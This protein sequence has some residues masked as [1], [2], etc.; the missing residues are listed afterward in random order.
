M[1]LKNFIVFEGIDGAGTSTQIKIFADSEYKDKMDFSAEPTSNETG[2]FLRK[3]LKGDIQLDPRT[4]A[5]LFA[6]DRAEH[7]WGKDGIEEKC[8]NGK[9]CISDRYLFS[10]LTYQSVTCGEELPSLLNSP[11]PLP[12][13]LFFFEIEPEVS[14]SRI[15]G[16]ETR[17][18]Y[19]KVDFLKET[20][21]RYK[22]IISEFEKKNT[23]MKIVRINAELPIEKVTE[24]IMKELEG[25]LK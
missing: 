7:I 12:E 5:Y 25:K 8:R 9:I 4:S 22:K 15:G 1:V 21:E 2:K 16:R 19:E 10:S 13:I 23:G 3:M 14:L 17:E 24:I 18:I 11:F 20:E 6:A